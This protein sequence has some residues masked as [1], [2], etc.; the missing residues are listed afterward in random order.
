MSRTMGVT[1][2]VALKGKVTFVTQV[3]PEKIL[4]SIGH[5][6][7]TYDLCYDSAGETSKVGDGLKAGKRGS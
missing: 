1:Y 4:T 6:S 2:K 3:F 7:S 5:V